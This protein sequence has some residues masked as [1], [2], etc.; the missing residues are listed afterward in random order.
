MKT[1]NDVT[2]PSKVNRFQIPTSLAVLFPHQYSANSSY[3][4]FP[5]FSAH[6]TRRIPQKYEII[7]SIIAII[8]T[9]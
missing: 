4:S 9:V 1:I 3:F 5:I 6:S 2:P 8:T 7:E